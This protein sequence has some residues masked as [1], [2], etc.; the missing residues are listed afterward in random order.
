MSTI[1]DFTPAKLKA[2]IERYSGGIEEAPEDGTPYSRQDADWVPSPNGG[3]GEG[4]ATEFSLTQTGHSFSVLD[5]IRYNGSEWVKAQA[6]DV[7]T[8]GVA[9][10]VEVSGDNFKAAVSGRYDSTA[11][12]MTS[13]TYY[14][15]D[16]SVAGGVTEEPPSIEQPIIYAEDA[17]WFI[18]LPYRPSVNQGPAT[19]PDRKN[20]LING[21]FRIW[22]RGTASS[23]NSQYTADR[24][25]GGSQ[26]TSW[27]RQYDADYDGLCLSVWSGTNMYLEQGVELE[28]SGNQA[29]FILNEDYTLSAKF[30]AP[31][32]TTFSFIVQWR[33]ETGSNTNASTV[34]TAGSNSHTCTGGI[35]TAELTFNLNVG[36]NATNN[37][38]TVLLF[39]DGLSNENVRFYEAKLEKGNTATEIEYRPIGE[40]L[41]LCQRYYWKSSFEP[42]AASGANYAS[43]PGRF[44]QEMRTAPTIQIVSISD[45]PGSRT[46]NDGIA[47]LVD[48]KSFCRINS[49]SSQF[50]T[51][52][53]GWKIQYTADAE[54]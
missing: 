4:G 22:Q 35:D 36:P 31:T 38:L 9:V 7:D 23:G 11:H 34:V 32:G 51:S 16:S 26:M 43:G 25:L 15:L 20:L 41:A 27:S 54:L 12:G 37:Q 5:V 8:L 14:F 50:D 28:A 30:K 53:A 6:N 46:V 33:D 10:V 45:A 52:R 17:D 13:A 40:E 19:Q 44:P 18:I 48:S 42:M 49:P 29:P 39:I 21:D 2:W 24:W 3:G 1:K 47:Q